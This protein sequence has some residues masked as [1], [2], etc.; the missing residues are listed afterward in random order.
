L[1]A[2]LEI[3]DSKNIFFEIRFAKRARPVVSLKVIIASHGI[4]H[5]CQRRDASGSRSRWNKAAGHPVSI[6]MSIQDAFDANGNRLM[7]RRNATNPDSHGG[8]SCLGVHF[9]PGG[10]GKGANISGLPRR[11]RRRRHAMR[12]HEP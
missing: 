8:T 1:G 5:F 6:A 11:C 3:P 12:V 7:E 9:Q 4:L 2:S 10:T